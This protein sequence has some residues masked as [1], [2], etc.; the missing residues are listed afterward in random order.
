MVTTATLP[1]LD[2]VR[3]AVGGVPDPELP[4]VT[5]A[6]LGMVHDVRVDGHHVHVELLPT[7]SGCPATDVIGED[8]RTAVAAVD[9]VTEVTVRFRFD[10]VWTPAR[11]TTEGH[12]ALRSFGIA[13]P[14]SIPPSTTSLPVLP[15]T[16]PGP[17]DSSRPCPY[18][19]STD[20]VRDGMFGPTPCR[21]VRYCNACA[22][23][24]EAFKS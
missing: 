14:V 12:D 4:P 7:W 13:P 21:D 17:V 16:G 5:L 20:T 10:P 3:A 19:G 22:Q 11:I 9:G 18:C 6:M 15:T 24:F 23:P 1:D 2:D 8:V